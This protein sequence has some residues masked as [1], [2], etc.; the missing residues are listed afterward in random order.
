MAF[1]DVEALAPGRRVSVVKLNPAGREIARYPAIVRPDAC[2]DHWFS[3]EARWVMKRVEVCG[4]VFAPG[5]TLLEYFSPDHWYNAFRVISP[6]GTERGIYGNV[7]YPVS[8]D[9]IDDEVVVTWR[10]LYLDVIRLNDD[11][12]LICDEDELAESGL[13]MSN[14]ELDA[15]IRATGVEML[16]LAKSALFPF[17]PQSG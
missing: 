13:A 6:D 3:V 11:T 12:V 9:T 4:L 7:T 14:P 8:I 17:Q 15:R 5:D 16:A 1:E 2:P 10:D